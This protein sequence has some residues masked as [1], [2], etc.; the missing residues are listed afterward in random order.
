MSA[1]A[2]TATSQPDGATPRLETAAKPAS[3]A[4]IPSLDGLRAIS[5]I[6]D[7]HGHSSGTLGSPTFS[8]GSVDIASL[9]VRVFFVISG[10]LITGLLLHERQATGTISLPRFYLRRTL[11]IFP[12]YYF[13][14]GML[15]L[16]Q[17]LGWIELRPRDLL[18]GLTFTE[19]YSEDHSWYVGHIWSLSVEE[20]FYLLWPAVML[21]AG[22]RRGLRLAAG[23]VLMAPVFRVA[24]WMLLP[25]WREYIT[26]HSFETIAD[27]IAVGCVLAGSR[28]ALW[29]RPGYRRLLSGPWFALVPLGLLV[30]AS[31]GSA[32]IKYPIGMTLMNLGIA[33][34]IDRC[35]RFPGDLVGKL[36]NSRPFVFVGVMSYSIYLWQQPFL[37]RHSASV[38]ATFPF[39]FALA[40]VA[41]LGSYY[42]IEKP[43]LRARVWIERRYLA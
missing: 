42:L 5:I 35:V 41:A 38:T 26:G 12:A 2:V 6:A 27:A 40:T 23:F 19:N 21:L 25:S 1:P 4:R 30:V 37:N 11:R 13:F 16:A 14:L 32:R 36:L 18:H 31:F 17:G 39:N 8:L 29:Q 3:G 15:A 9:G 10:F 7:L 20:Q 33:L 22:T 28:E 34:C 43:A 24:E